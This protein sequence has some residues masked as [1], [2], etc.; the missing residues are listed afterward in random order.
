MTVL[1]PDDDSEPQVVF[2]GGSLAFALCEAGAGLGY[3]II[4]PFQ[5]L[6]KK[7]KSEFPNGG[8]CFQ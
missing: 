4:C 6:L 8:V 5:F 3:F 7:D 1:V 2:K